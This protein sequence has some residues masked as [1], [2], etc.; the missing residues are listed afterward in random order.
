LTNIMHNHQP[1]WDNCHQLMSTS[2]LLM[3]IGEYTKQPEHS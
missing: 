1:N 2:S 3:S